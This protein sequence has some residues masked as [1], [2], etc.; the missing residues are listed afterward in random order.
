MKWGL[1]V[2]KDGPVV[3]LSCLLNPPYKMLGDHSFLEH[4]LFDS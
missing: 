2:L 4:V 3:A 1:F